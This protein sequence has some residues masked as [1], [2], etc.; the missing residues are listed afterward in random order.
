M[1]RVLR[2]GRKDIFFCISKL[3][4]YFSIFFNENFHKLF[5]VLKCDYST[6]FITL[7]LGVNLYWVIRTRHTKHSWWKAHMAGVMLIPLLTRKRKY[8]TNEKILN[9][10]KISKFITKHHPHNIVNKLIELA[11]SY[12]PIPEY[13][14]RDILDICLLQIKNYQNDI[15]FIR[16]WNS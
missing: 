9:T 15:Y 11:N 7:H 12:K 13:L 8:T 6:L 5:L 3:F 10:F 1:E 14:T 16:I 4:P 2:Y